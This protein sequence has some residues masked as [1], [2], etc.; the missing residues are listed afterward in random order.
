MIKK[1]TEIEQEIDGQSSSDIL[2]SKKF[3]LLL[4][5]KILKAGK[6]TNYPKDI[7]MDYLHIFAMSKYFKD[8]DYKFFFLKLYENNKN[9]DYEVVYEIIESIQRYLAYNNL[10]FVEIRECLFDALKRFPDNPG[11]IYIVLYAAWVA[12][13]SKYKKLLLR[14][15][16]HPDKNIAKIVQEGLKNA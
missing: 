6:I 14:Y 8:M 3:I 10:K 4:S 5:K 15:K 2:G 16:N 13:I 12:N 9:S 7:N 11:I 1:Q